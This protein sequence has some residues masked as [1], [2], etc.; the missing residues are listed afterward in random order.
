MI[1]P[2]FPYICL[3]RWGLELPGPLPLAVMLILI[4]RYMSQETEITATEAQRA[5][6][7][8]RQA[9][10]QTER[11]APWLELGEMRLDGQ[12]GRWI[13]S[14]RVRERERER[15]REEKNERA[16]EPAR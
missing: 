5:R 4:V 9:G 13:E 15:E 11:Q 16:K 12:R 7:T 8:D 14:S 6:Q 10:R 2:F 1:H 3:H